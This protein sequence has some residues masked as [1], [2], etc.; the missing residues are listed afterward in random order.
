MFAPFL[1]EGIG[2]HTGAPVRALVEMGLPGTGVVF[3]ADD[4]VIPARPEFVSPTGELATVLT[5]DGV[6]ISTVEHLLATLAACGETDVRV[7]VEGGELPILDGSALPWIQA[8]ED[9]GAEL[10]P[11]FI[12]IS[13]RIELGAGESSASITPLNIDREPSIHLVIDYNRIDFA[14][15]EITY[16]PCRDNFTREIAPARTF[17]FESDVETILSAGL[18]RGGTLDCALVLG[19]NGPVNPD[20]QRFEN[21]PARHKLLDAVGDLFL[22]GGLPWAKVELVRPG[23]KLIQELALL[24]APLSAPMRASVNL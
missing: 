13:E 3:I 19:A 4:M 6:S 17:A 15:Q 18:A 10:D 1:K 24:A 2:L 20:G 8:L 9:S 12:E 22:L 7:A 16:C 11:R 5:R 23:H 21:E 14:P